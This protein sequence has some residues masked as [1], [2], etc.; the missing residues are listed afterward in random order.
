[1]LR[2]L[3]Q[4]LETALTLVVAV[5]VLPEYAV[6]VR[7]R[8]GGQ[9]PPV[10]GYLYSGAVGWVVFWT[11][12]GARAALHAAANA[13]RSLPLKLVGGIAAGVTVAWLLGLTEFCTRWFSLL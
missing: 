11:T 7:K 1:M 13:I 6:S 2:L 5:V 9:P 4:V 3:A 12:R 8:R 10:V